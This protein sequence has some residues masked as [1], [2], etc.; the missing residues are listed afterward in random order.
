MSIQELIGVM[1]KDNYQDE[2]LV[3]NCCSAFCY[4]RQQC[5]ILVIVISEYPQDTV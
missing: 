3:W 1:R 2:I 5:T 4:L